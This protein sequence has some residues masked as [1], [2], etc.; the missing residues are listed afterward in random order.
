MTVCFHQDVVVAIRKITLNFCLN[1]S[2]VGSNF[3]FMGEISKKNKNPTTAPQKSNMDTKKLPCLKGVAFSKPS[4]WVSMLVFGGVANLQQNHPSKSCN[5]NFP[6]KYTQTNT[7]INAVVQFLK[8]P[9]RFDQND[10]E[11][12]PHLHRLHQPFCF[13]SLPAGG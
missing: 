7:N 13:C 9:A 1:K 4:F 11:H 10:G 8:S 2:Q 12:G 6:N 3:C 5:L